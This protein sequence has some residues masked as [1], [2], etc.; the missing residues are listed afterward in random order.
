MR[1]AV[2]LEGQLGDVVESITA[3]KGKQYMTL[4]THTINF[5]NLD[6][7]IR[8]ATDDEALFEM[9][10]MA[11]SHVMADLAR[12]ANVNLEADS[13]K[14]EFIRNLNIMREAISKITPH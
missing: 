3:V 14:D 11:H 10:M 2:D 7:A 8:R 1:T 9:S 5:Q 4:L 13:E 6:S 12:A